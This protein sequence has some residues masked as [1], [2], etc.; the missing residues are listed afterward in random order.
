[1]KPKDKIEKLID[2]LVLGGT[3]ESDERILNDALAV[4]ERTGPS[5]L[6]AKLKTAIRAAAAI[7]VAAMIAGLV[8]FGSLS[9]KTEKVVLNKIETSEGKKNDITISCPSV[10]IAKDSRVQMG[11]CEN[12]DGSN[13]G[14]SAEGLTREEACRE[15]L[16]QF[17]YAIEN[18]DLTLV[19]Q[20]FPASQ[21]WDNE[22]LKETLGLSDNTKIVKLLEIGQPYNEEDSDTELVLVPNYYKCTDGTNQ[23]VLM[24]IQFC[25]IDNKLSCV[26][27]GSYGCASER[28]V[29]C[30]NIR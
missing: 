2:E 7:I 14:I 18:A 5:K 29:F 21:N 10:E 25:Q 17:W 9:D 6:S 13:Y 19:R 23:E 16:E 20:L 24:M 8:V 26:I 3:K 27:S 30:C 4:F 15:I 12:A 28:E 11:L 22:E 1:M